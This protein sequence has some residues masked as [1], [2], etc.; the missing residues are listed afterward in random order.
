MNLYKTLISSIVLSI[1]IWLNTTFAGQPIA[2]INGAACSFNTIA[3]AIAAAQPNDVINI[4]NGTH[5][6]L[7]G[8][9]SIDL[10]LVASRGTT[11]C[12][13]GSNAFCCYRLR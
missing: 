7:I 9:I 6:Q 1:L 4:K 2:S 10:T 12:E 8:E 11:G 13:I 5:T 3:D